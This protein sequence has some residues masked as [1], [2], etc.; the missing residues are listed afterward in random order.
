LVYGRE[1][2]TIVLFA[3][4]IRGDYAFFYINK[5]MGMGIDRVSLN[6]FETLN[7]KCDECKN[8]VEYKT[9]DKIEHLYMMKEL[10][11]K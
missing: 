3:I 10:G 6:D 5:L 9:D 8:I 2:G 1:H 4:R 11:G 7:K